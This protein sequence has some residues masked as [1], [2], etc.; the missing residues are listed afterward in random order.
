MEVRA[1]FFD[2]GETLVHPHPSFPELLTSAL[3][4]EGHSVDEAVVRERL[5]VVSDR[6]LRAST[7]NELWSTSAERSRAFWSSI[8]ESFLGEL[9]I[10]WTERLAEHLYAT[11]TDLSNYRLFPDAL[12]ALGALDERGVQLGLV[13]NFEEWLELLLEKL[14]LLRFFDVRVISGIEG[15]EKPDPKIFRLALDR[16]GV[17]AGESV[18]VGDNVHFDVEPA[19]EVGMRPV[20]ID[21]RG[22]YPDHEGVRITSLSELPEVLGL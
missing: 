18:Y 7:E 17:E 11:F 5:W 13:S 16:A 20:L 22:R 21:R 3:R 6:F 4:E 19:A 10:E 2:A 15:V 9:G 12:G 8:Y 14:D 1:V